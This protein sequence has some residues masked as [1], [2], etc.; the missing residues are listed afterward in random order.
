MEHGLGW[1]RQRGVKLAKKP[2]KAA[3]AAVVSI[4]ESR[5][6]LTGLGILESATIKTTDGTTE[7]QQ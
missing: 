7:L 1:G 2:K 3:N 5:Q 4:I 6:L